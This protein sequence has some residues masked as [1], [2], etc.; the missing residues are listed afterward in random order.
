VQRCKKIHKEKII[1]LQSFGITN[2]YH[3]QLI[4]SGKFRALNHFFPSMN[5]QKNKK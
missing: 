2:N 3:L 1:A 4:T 5:N